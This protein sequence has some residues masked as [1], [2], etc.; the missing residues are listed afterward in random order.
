MTV[1]FFANRQISTGWFIPAGGK[2]K[3]G[4]TGQI[5]DENKPPRLFSNLKGAHLALYWWLRGVSYEKHYYGGGEEGDDY[6]I[7]TEP[8]AER[9]PKDYQT[10]MVKLEVVKVGIRFVRAARR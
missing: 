6:G 2:H 4:H 7:E 3:G 10:V 1:K 5:P 9:D 8:K